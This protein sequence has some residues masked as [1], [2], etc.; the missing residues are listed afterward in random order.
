M[1]KG[2]DLKEYVVRGTN[3]RHDGKLYR[4]GEVIKLSAKEAKRLAS[5][6]EEVKKEEKAASGGNKQEG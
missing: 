2:K 4:E 5:F 1:A 3:I 6:L